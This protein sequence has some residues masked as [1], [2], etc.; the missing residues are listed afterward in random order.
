MGIDYVIDLDC[1]PKQALGIEEL[2]G[3]V[4]ASNRAE[5]MLAIARQNG[6]QRPPDEITF[7]I[8]INRNGEIETTDVTVQA[9][10]DQAA[11]LDDHRGACTA[12]PA[13]RDRPNGFGCYDTINYPIE[14]DTEQFLLSRLP[15]DLESPSG[16][17]FASAM[18]DFA[19]DGEPSANMRSQGET[20]F[21]AREPFRRTWPGLEVT[22]DQIFHM[23]FHV[24]HLQSTHAMLLC[25][26]FGL[27]A[28]TAGDEV[29]ASTVRPESPNSH[30]M[31][32]HLDALAFAAS[33]KLDVLIDG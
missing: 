33:Q 28:L 23:M 17:M 26:F 22:T 20:F 2:V 11:A 1:A 12:C 25:M 9:L 29:R 7:Q 6:D 10:I 31:V 32:E 3:Y 13:N 5:T 8:A 30:Q 15:D 16:F 18:R 19:W 24:G 14:P 27:A 4:K 21:R